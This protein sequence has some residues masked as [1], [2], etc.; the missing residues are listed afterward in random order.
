MSCSP[1]LKRSEAHHGIR[2]V[3]MANAHHGVCL[4]NIIFGRTAKEEQQELDQNDGR[5]QKSNPM[6]NGRRDGDIKGRAREELLHALHEDLE[7]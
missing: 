1:T 5:E 3:T 2:Y 7:A 4:D 6:K